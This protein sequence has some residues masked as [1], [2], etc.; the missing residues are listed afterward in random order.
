MAKVLADAPR[1]FVP[2]GE[3]PSPIASG[4]PASPGIATGN[5][6]TSSAAAVEAAERGE[7]VILMRHETSPE[8]VAGMARS[9]GV[10]TARGGLAS[11]AAVVA[12]GWGIPAVV[13]AG[14][15]ELAVGQLITIDGS[16]GAVYAGRLD[17]D[18]QVDP[19]VATLTDWA[20]E[21]GIDLAAEAPATLDAG[22]AGSAG[23]ADSGPTWRVAYADHR[24]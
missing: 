4:L 13:G 14:G 9:A 23:G 24:R 15:L 20:S 12:R 7:T 3:L 11:H 10:L 18:W 1:T 8:D 6:V 5:V 19:E 21:L 17:G 22:S 2:R 16:T